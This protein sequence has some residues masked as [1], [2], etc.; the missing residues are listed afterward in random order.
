VKPS[1]VQGRSDMRHTV[2]AA[3]TAGRPNSSLL[4]SVEI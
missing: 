2:G 3:G 1:D 4:I